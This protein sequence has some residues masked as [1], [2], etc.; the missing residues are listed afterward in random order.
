MQVDKD[1]IGQLKQDILD[2]KPFSSVVPV[3][4]HL[5]Y[6]SMV[7]LASFIYNS[8]PSNITVFNISGGLSSGMTILELSA[9]LI[10]P[11]EEDS[12]IQTLC[13]KLD[14]GPPLSAIS[15]A[16]FMRVLGW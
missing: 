7:S 6:Q 2:Y 10:I 11:S 3:D 9:S 8:S 16:K 13:S 15:K 4:D 12:F 5:S 1:L 14:N